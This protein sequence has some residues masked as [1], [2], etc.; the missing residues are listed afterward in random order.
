M[1]LASAPALP[2]LVPSGQTIRLL[3]Y[4]PDLARDVRTERRPEAA[5]T[6]QA[7][8]L[9]LPRGPWDIAP[10]DEAG[11]CPYGALLVDGLVTRTV[12]LGGED[13]STQLLG[14]GDLIRT[15]ELDQHEALVPAEVRWTV[16]EPA[17]LALLD[18]RFLLTVRRWPEIVAALFERV[19]AQGVRHGTHRALCQLPRVEDRLHALL[20][21]LAERWGRVTPQGVTLPLKLT[22]ELLGQLVGAK[23]PTVSLAIKQLEKL[24]TVQRRRDGAWLLRE[25]WS[26]GAATVDVAHPSVGF[27]SIAGPEPAPLLRPVPSRAPLAATDASGASSTSMRHRI[28]HMRARHER[29]IGEVRAMLARCAEAKERAAAVRADVA[30][31]RRRRRGGRP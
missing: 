6:A 29:T 16:L 24:G 2:S 17:T 11:A 31:C 8:L 12:L 15:E 4:D 19:A 1:S 22:H 27:L 28:D 5:R 13:A 20:W 18:E 3:E 25:R 10:I 21:F 14:R 7:H 30:R 26:R 23:R 9:T